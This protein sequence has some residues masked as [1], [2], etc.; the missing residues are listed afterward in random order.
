MCCSASWILPLRIWPYESASLGK[1]EYQGSTETFTAFRKQGVAFA[2]VSDILVVCDDKLYYVKDEFY[3]GR[4]G[5]SV[6]L[7][8]SR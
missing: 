6:H 4:R 8:L 1:T 3:W 2:E 7:N 5:P